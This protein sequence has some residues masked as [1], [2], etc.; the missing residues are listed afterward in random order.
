MFK[1]SDSDND[2]NIRHMC[3]G[4][5]FRE[6]PRV[7][8]FEQS[9][10]PA[11]EEG[12]YSGEEEELMTDENSQSAREEEEKTE[13]PRREESKTSKTMQTIEVSTITSPVVSTTLSN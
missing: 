11:Q 6:V 1:D 12:F 3:N 10:K 8:L 4:R 13:E 5:T 9:R 7:N 2:T